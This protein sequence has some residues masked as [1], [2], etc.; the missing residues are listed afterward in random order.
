MA[1]TFL[2]KVEDR[3]RLDDLCEFLSET[4]YDARPLDDR[5]VAVVV[6]DSLDRAVVEAELG[7]YLRMWERQD[8]ANTADLR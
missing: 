6:P 5:T 7:V 8:P 3:A 4:A 2:L 1:Q